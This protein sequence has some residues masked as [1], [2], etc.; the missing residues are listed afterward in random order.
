MLFVEIDEIKA[1]EQIN[2]GGFLSCLAGGMAGALIGT[3]AGLIPSAVTGDLD[4]MKQSAAAGTSLGIW[5]GA[6]APLP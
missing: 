1:Q 3:I 6:G 2:G 5:V 4:Y